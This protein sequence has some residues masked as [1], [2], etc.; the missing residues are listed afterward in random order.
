MA[1]TFGLREIS[2]SMGHQVGGKAANLGKLVQAGFPVPDGLAVPVETY[3][4]FLDDNSLRPRIASILED[5]DFSQEG[6]V[7]EASREI[8][9][10]FSNA[11]LSSAP[12]ILAELRALD[13]DGL[14]A[15]RS[16]AVSE[17]LASASFAG[18][19][20]TYLNVSTAEVPEHVLKCWAS[21]WNARAMSYRHQAEVPQLQAGIAVVV[22]RMVDARASGI[23]FTS[24]PIH[25]RPGR[26][27]IESSWG[28]GE[29]I[30]SG[31]VTPDRFVCDKGRRRVVERE[32]NRKVTAVFLSADGSRPVEVDEK[33][34]TRPSL[35][36]DEVLSLIS[37][38][39]RIE[40]HFGSPQDVEFALEGDEVFVLQSR[41]ITT[42]TDDGGTLWTRAYGDEY[43]ADVTSPLFF[44]MLGE[45]L[46]KYVNHEGSRI[47]GYHNLT[48]KDL[49]KV[50]KGHVYFNASVL[51]EVFTYN[52]KFSRTKELLN[53]FPQRDQARIAQAGTKLARRLW[54]EVRIAFLDPDGTI[55]RTDK[56][57]RRWAAGF[58]LEL[59]RLDA[60]DLPSLTDRELVRE[61]DRLIQAS[62]KHYRLIRYGLVTH[63][64]GTNLM[65]KRWLQDWVDD[66][67]GVYYSRLI[68]GLDDNKTI[69]TNI[70][71]AKLARWAQR[72]EAARKALLERTSGEV[73]ELL[74]QD[75]DLSAFRTQLDLFL[76]DYGHR[77]H[78]REFYFP[79]WAEDPTLVIDVV[80]VLMVSE[81]GDLEK[82]EKEKIRMRKETEKEVLEKIG[83][84]RYGRLKRVL[85]RPILHYAQTYLGFRENQRFFLDHM[86]FR[87]RKVFLEFGRRLAQRGAISEAADVFFLTKEEVLDL[88]RAPRIVTAEVAVRKDDFLKY[89]SILPPKFLRGTAEFDDTVVR[90]RDAVRIQ[91]TSASPG[92]VTGTVRV[93]GSIGQLPEIRSGEIMVTSNTDP[94]WTAVFPK[95]GGL[96]TETGGILS[97]GA[98]VS[99]E[100]GIPAVTAVKD[101]TEILRT[102]QRVTL[103]G[104]DGTIY[105]LEA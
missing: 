4:A 75:P 52:P 40:E 61:Y 87:W 105:I 82:M 48:D 101:A 50:H 103:D 51:E 54:A 49:L 80:K 12:S 72:D 6:C 45:L 26:M 93:V 62:L 23:M 77:S 70:E 17:D 39:K 95:L 89:R 100:Y 31:L 53:Y 46:T 37:L 83:R 59:Q 104:N 92:V 2:E 81:V 42:L 76:R 34:Q 79:R 11:S 30:A 25:G 33:E 66:T 47:M 10:F 21:Y 20:D 98:V 27:I 35:T 16:S 28:L 99:R 8:K 91:G 14:W 65:V 68:S 90:D 56:A 22:Q 86:I 58:M 78:T 84:L 9:A 69:R 71:L 102:G 43:W 7:E 38:G 29:S 19:Q 96:I 55:F 24:D 18:Q 15:V 85:F 44:S 63:S 94:G 1:L 57:Y 36:K 3:D 13:P 32:V 64:I 60:L 74:R 97:H 88:I 67:S 5:V 73:V 41:P